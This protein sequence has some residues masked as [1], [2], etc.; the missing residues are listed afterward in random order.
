[1]VE[2]EEFQLKSP[3]PFLSLPSPLLLGDC[4]KFSCFNVRIIFGPFSC[5]HSE[6]KLF[7]VRKTLTGQHLADTAY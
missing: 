6:V 2:K 3:V 7:L 1:M 5:R 4:L